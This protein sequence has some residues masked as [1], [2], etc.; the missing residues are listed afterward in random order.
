MKT[1]IIP[2]KPH[3]TDIILQTRIRNDIPNSQSH[4]FGSYEESQFPELEEKHN[5]AVFREP[6]N[7]IYNCHGL[8][9]ASRRTGITDNNALKTILHDDGYQEVERADVLPGDIILYYYEDGDVE[10]SGVVISKP[11]SQL[12]IPW[13]LSKWGRFKEVVHYANDCPYEF[14]N[15]KYYRVTEWD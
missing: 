2:N 6:P 12:K 10:H 4:E 3:Y 11:V 15:A 9:F 13:V 7:P 1:I 8:T 5:R 14:R